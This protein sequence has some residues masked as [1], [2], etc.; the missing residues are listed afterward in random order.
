MTLNLAKIDNKP[1]VVLK[2]DQIKVVKP[3]EN[4]KPKFHLDLSKID[5]YRSVK[6]S[7]SQKPQYKVKPAQPKP[8]T[9]HETPKFE[10]KGGPK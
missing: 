8:K 2:K 4:L 1:I 10:N 6:F 3:G 5:K 9:V 7:K